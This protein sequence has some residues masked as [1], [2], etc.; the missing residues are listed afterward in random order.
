MSSDTFYG[1][2]TQP[3]ADSFESVVDAWE[4]E[5]E[6]SKTQCK[7]CKREITGLLIDKDANYVCVDHVHASARRCWYAH[8][9]ARAKVPNAPLEAPELDHLCVHH[10]AFLSRQAQIHTVSVPS[11]PNPVASWVKVVEDDGSVT[12]TAQH[13]DGTM[14]PE[15][16]RMTKEAPPF[17]D[18]EITSVTTSVARE[19][20]IDVERDAIEADPAYDADVAKAEEAFKICQAFGYDAVSMLVA[21]WERAK[22]DELRYVGAPA[23]LL[24]YAKAAALVEQLPPELQ[25]A[26]GQL[27]TPDGGHA[28]LPF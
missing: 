13:A 18:D 16:L 8:C 3:S 12:M 26:L 25:K 2:G 22:D 10:G 19:I 4:K 17:S 15:T 9:R 5:V 27:V 24:D 28:T 23:R 7:W 6:R 14:G 11:D 1:P 20:R 21:A